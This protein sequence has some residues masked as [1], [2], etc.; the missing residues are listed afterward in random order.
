MSPYIPQ[1]D[2][3]EVNSFG[4]ADTPAKLCY[5]ILQSAVDFVNA[6]PKPHRWGLLSDAHKA[7]VCAEREFYRTHIAPYEDEAIKRNGD[8]T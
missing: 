8:V 2:R 4:T 1:D 5:K 7:M 3:D 6:Q